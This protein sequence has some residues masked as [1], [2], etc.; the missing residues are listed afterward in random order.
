MNNLL[1]I[2]LVLVMTGCANQSFQELSAEEKELKQLRESYVAFTEWYY[3]K[4]DL[5]TLTPERHAKILSMYIDALVASGDSNL[6]VKA[7]DELLPKYRAL[8]NGDHEIATLV[9][10]VKDTEETFA[11]YRKLL[12]QFVMYLSKCGLLKKPLDSIPQQFDGTLED[13]AKG[14]DDYSLLGVLLQGSHWNPSEKTML[15][16]ILRELKKADVAGN[17]AD[18]TKFC[19]SAKTHFLT[20]Y[21]KLGKLLKWPGP[22]VT[23]EQ[24]L[25]EAQVYQGCGDNTKAIELYRQASRSIWE[26]PFGYWKNL[27]EFLS[28]WYEASVDNEK[29]LRHLLS[30][31]RTIRQQKHPLMA[32]YEKQLSDLEAKIIAFWGDT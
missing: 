9:K 13:L 30:R 27:L 28:G 16:I 2:I 10:E 25:L 21:A 22:P 5:E 32:I 4:Q 3:N 7:R 17:A 26:E 1:K 18:I 29:E 19:K 24:L 11:D 20:L 8:K 12:S 15:A 23:C 31:I 14:T 6:A